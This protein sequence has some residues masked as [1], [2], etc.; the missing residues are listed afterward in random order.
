MVRLPWD[1]TRAP[2]GL[3]M[4]PRS[5]VASHTTRRRA[6]ESPVAPA[7]LVGAEPA[8]WT[9]SA[10]P[11]PVPVGIRLHSNIEQR[12]QPSALSI[13]AE[14]PGAEQEDEDRDP[15]VDP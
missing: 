7:P 12:A 3:V 14:Q 2:S 11:L 15:H 8:I 13:P 1:A 9:G 5:C 10:G 4:W 6:D